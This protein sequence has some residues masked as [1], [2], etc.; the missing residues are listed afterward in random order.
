[1]K[2]FKAILIT[3]LLGIGVLLMIG[4]FVPEIDEEIEIQVNRP[5]I[6][7]FASMLN[8]NDLTEWVD[9]LT[10]VEQTSGILA[11]PGSTFKMYYQTKETETVYD[12]E[13]LELKPMKSVKFRMF[14]DMMDV[15]VSVQFKADGLATDITVYTQVKGQ[16]LPV[17][18][19]L[20][21]MKSVIMDQIEQDFENF[22]TL[23]ETDS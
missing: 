3:V 19:M 18:C 10:K 21:L 2:F 13:I 7:V 8:T 22:K 17:K 15:L 12:M 5:I 9:G 4:V 23:Q 14:N 1:M 11:M 16:G 20:P 6:T